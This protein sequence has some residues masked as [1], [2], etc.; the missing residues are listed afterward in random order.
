MDGDGNVGFGDFVIVSGNYGNDK[1]WRKAFSVGG[2][3]DLTFRFVDMG[4]R[5]ESGINEHP[6]AKR[7]VV[8]TLPIRV[9]GFDDSTSKP[10][11]DRSIDRAFAAESVLDALLGPL[12]KGV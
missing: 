9:V 10:Q 1:V 2:P 8:D 6:G 5:Q 11:D 7:D 3:T 12:V 4:N